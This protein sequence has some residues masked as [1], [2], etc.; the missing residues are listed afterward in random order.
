LKIVIK[1]YTDNDLVGLQVSFPEEKP[2]EW[3][4]LDLPLVTIINNDEVLQNIYED[5]N[6]GIE[7]IKDNLFADFQIAEKVSNTFYE[8]NEEKIFNI[9]CNY[10]KNQL[11]ESSFELGK[12]EEKEFA[13]NV[14]FTENVTSTHNMSFDFYENESGI[15]CVL[16][17]NKSKYDK[18][19]IMLF[20]E[21]FNTVINQLVEN[22]ELFSHFTID[23]ISFDFQS[24]KQPGE[25]KILLEENF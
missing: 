10:Y 3:H 9:K 4:K 7:E 12:T 13:A 19:H 17:Y 6:R 23:N 15:N 18:S 20:I 2:N 25:N 16:I 5:L 21:R 14:I 8:N 11:P 1:K 24:K 22:S